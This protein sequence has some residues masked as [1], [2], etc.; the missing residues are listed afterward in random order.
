MSDLCAH[1]FK[2]FQFGLSLD[3]K[4]IPAGKEF[5]LG[6]GGDR[7]AGQI[8]ERAGCE[9]LLPRHGRRKEAGLIRR[10]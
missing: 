6:S 9:F 5:V 7:C 4:K 1:L 3:R 2:D 8:F 10:A